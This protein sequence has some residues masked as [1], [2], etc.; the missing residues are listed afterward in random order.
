MPL[1]IGGA[2]DDANLWP[3]PRRSIE[4][5]WNAEAKDRLE[6]KLRDL[7]Y[8]GTLDVRKA[9]K[10]FADDWTEAYRHYVGGKRDA[11]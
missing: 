4:P 7:V 2:D 6:W 11:E 8:S 1:G 9:Q 3:E 10:A 5:E